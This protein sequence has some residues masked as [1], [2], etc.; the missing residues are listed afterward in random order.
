MIAFLPRRVR[1]ALALAVLAVLLAAAS[2]AAAFDEQTVLECAFRRAL[3]MV[4]CKPPEEFQFMGL[5]EGVYVYNVHFGSKFTEF[6]I[7]MDGDLAIIS[8]Q[9][10]HGRRAS[11]TI[12]RDFP[13]GCVDLSL[14][15]APCSPLKTAR[16]CGK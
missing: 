1:A 12:I 15:P 5:R 10:W 8:S 7:Q 2:P 13:N 16:C 14:E 4:T 11:A 3:S 6:Y 9:A